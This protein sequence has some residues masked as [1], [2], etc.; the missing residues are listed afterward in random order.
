MLAGMALVLASALG[1]GDVYRPIVTNVPPVQ[2]APQP[3]KYAMVISCDTGANPTVPTTAPNIYQVCNNASTTGLG[4]LVD[5]SG[6]SLMVRINLGNGPRWIGLSGRGSTGYTANADGT[7]NSFSISTSLETNQVNTS[8]L[9]AN[10]GPT[11]LLSTSNYLYVVEPGN[12]PSA[13]PSVAVMSGSTPSIVLEIP[14][15]DPQNLTANQHPV[16]MAG[17]YNAQRVYAIAQGPNGA[18]CPNTTGNGSITAI[19]TATNTISAVLPA[20]VCPIYGI[21]SPDNRRTFVLNQGSGT[22]TVIDSQQNQLDLDANNPNN[23]NAPNFRNGV[24]TLPPGPNG[25]LPQP[26]WADYYSTGSILAVASAQSN[27]LTLINVA[28]DSFGN[29]TPYFGQ[30]I[31]TVPV[32]NSPSSVAVLQEASGT[33]RAYVAN[34][35]DETVSDVSLISN[36]VLATVPVAGHPISVAATTGTPTGKVYV[37][38]PDTNVMTIISTQNDAISN[39]LPLVGNGIQVRVTAP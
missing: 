37:V 20:G 32:G 6:D 8:T 18:S 7:I 21:M 29:D 27:T 13:T 17:N 31:A 35:A 12:S 15:T 25:K 36:Q 1:C 9:L 33:P 22:I 24:I 39:S 34:Y 16:N 11:T 14:I 4:S 19:E 38:S 10:A 2:P 30:I 5:F 26:V 23:P 3:A 28:L